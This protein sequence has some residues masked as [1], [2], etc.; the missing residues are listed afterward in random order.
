MCT[1]V[2]VHIH[3]RNKSGIIR[4]YYLLLPPFLLRML[5]IHVDLSNVTL[6]DPNV[7]RGLYVYVYTS[8][9]PGH[10]I[11]LTPNPEGFT[12]S[13][14]IEDHDRM[15]FILSTLAMADGN[16]KANQPAHVLPWK[17]HPNKSD[18]D[19][20]I[21]QFR[22]YTPRNGVNITP[23]TIELDP[24]RPL[25]TL[26]IRIYEEVLVGIPSGEK[27]KTDYRLNEV[28]TNEN[29]FISMYKNGNGGGGGVVEEKSSMK[30][31]REF[32]FELPIGTVHLN[33]LEL[34]SL[35][36]LKRGSKETI[37]LPLYDDRLKYIQPVNRGSVTGIDTEKES[38]RGY[39]SLHVTS[40][41][42]DSDA[43][44]IKMWLDRHYTPRLWQQREV[45]IASKL[46]QLQEVSQQYLKLYVDSFPPFKLPFASV[47]QK[48]LQPPSPSSSSSQ[49]SLFGYKNILIPNTANTTDIHMP[50][51]ESEVMQNSIIPVGYYHLH[52]T[53][54]DGINHLQEQFLSSIFDSTC[55]GYSIE[56]S[57]VVTT[58]RRY[59]F[60]LGKREGS[61]GHDDDD[62]DELAKIQSS[63]CSYMEVISAVLTSIA[64]AGKYRSDFRIVGK[65]R[66]KSMESIDFDRL[67]GASSSDD[68]EVA[69]RVIQEICHILLQ[70]RSDVK[71]GYLEGDRLWSVLCH[72][73]GG[74][75]DDAHAVKNF[76]KIRLIGGWNHEG[77][78][79]LQHLLLY[80]TPVAILGSVTDSFPGVKSMQ[81]LV[82]PDIEKAEFAWKRGLKT[83]PLYDRIKHFI[84]GTLENI[85]AQSGAHQ[86]G[87]LIPLF[88]LLTM[89]KRG[90]DLEC[91][92]DK[93][94]QY[95]QPGD[96][97]TATK[98]YKLCDAFQTHMKDAGIKKPHL[99]LP[100]LLLEGT[101]RT[102]PYLVGASHWNQN[103][104]VDGK[105]MIKF[106][107]EQRNWIN[108]V[109]SHKL[110]ATGTIQ[111]CDPHIMKYVSG[112][113]TNR[114]ASRFY[115]DALHG[116]AP[117]LY[118]L[119]GCT[120]D[121]IDTMSFC[122]MNLN[123]TDSMYYGND[124][125]KNGG[126]GGG[127][128]NRYKPKGDLD[129]NITWGLPIEE[130]I[131]NDNN[132]NIACIPILHRIPH[133]L[134]QQF[135]YLTRQLVLPFL[136]PV[137]LGKYHIPN[138][139]NNNNNKTRRGRSQQRYT[140]ISV[141]NKQKEMSDQS[142][143]VSHDV[144]I[145]SSVPT[146]DSPS[147]S[148]SA[149]L[150]QYI[151]LPH[152]IELDDLAN[153]LEMVHRRHRRHHDHNNTTIDSSIKY[154]RSDTGV[155]ADTIKKLRTVLEQ[156]P[157]ASVD[158][159]SSEMNKVFETR[160][161]Y[162]PLHA[163]SLQTWL[164]WVEFV[165][166][167]GE[168]IKNIYIQKLS[169]VFGHTEVIIF[170]NAKMRN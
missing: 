28:M 30:L 49:S 150:D 55:R 107:M 10:G 102:S 84:F 160:T 161:Y 20:M 33:W 129:G 76:N 1:R 52:N 125:N 77:L 4:V 78:Q 137:T 70:G 164:T 91:P 38:D 6:K 60:L 75:G 59:F 145:T 73:N 35:S 3:I 34:L 118:L 154:K 117:S 149:L 120:E 18:N 152:R 61:Y 148:I 53:K 65:D 98:I 22:D 21:N 99:R 157:I 140:T 15:T 163:T 12:T 124:K 48:Y 31:K 85:T 79:A 104:G 170:T 64:T 153:F 97:E 167:M 128:N 147:T 41:S 11:L 8:S 127:N 96:H 63:F 23:P 32:T 43:N 143:M 126:G 86:Y 27:S 14:Y 132:P 69:W 68:C 108:N 26:F 133:G 121:A 58:I 144:E 24:S 7:E 146:D 51:I 56:P 66:I 109:L 81:D 57:H 54:P 142:K 123:D 5:K 111:V 155:V 36:S 80:Y 138:S 42:M 131:R 136:P 13:S 166:K 90:L 141:N 44:M 105:N 159:E 100:T 62:D 29:N 16:N 103:G 165:L 169:P 46:N 113:L 88:N 37:E 74:D 135:H 162:I 130:I 116:T 47:Q 95:R 134:R 19:R 94:K 82:I 122:F 50:F 9:H 139:N 72:G 110:M 89:Y 119:L 93:S 87:I 168:Q 151:I 67:T 71:P 114:R 40:E 45:A 158:S 92:R 2:R 112:N 156:I 83:D 25:P 17:L 39:I 106:E 115:R 101:C